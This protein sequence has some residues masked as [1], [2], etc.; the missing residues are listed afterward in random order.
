MP[1]TFIIMISGPP[2]TGKTT[3]GRRISQVLQLPFLSKDRIKETLFDTLGWS[4][5]AWSRMLGAATVEL[6]YVLMETE[7]TANRSFLVESNFY[8][9]SATARFLELKQKYR[10]ETCQVLCHTESAAL[11]ERVKRRAESGRRHPGHVEHLIYDEIAAGLVDGRYDALA[12]GGTIIHLD[13]TDFEQID[14]PR[15]FAS[16]RAAIPP[17]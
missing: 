5:R 13:T 12:I 16:I 10:F 6:L 3:L 7:L 1:T 15:L 8:T 17:G 4:D 11:L 9:A 2:C 14:Y